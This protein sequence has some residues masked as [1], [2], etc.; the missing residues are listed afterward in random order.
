VVGEVLHAAHPPFLRRVGPGSRAVV[1]AGR[2]LPT[3]V[4]DRVTRAVG[5]L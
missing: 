1:L 2:F 3:S 5:G 4:R